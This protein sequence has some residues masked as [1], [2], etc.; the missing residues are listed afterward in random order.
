MKNSGSPDINQIDDA[1]LTVAVY[2]CSADGDLTRP[3]DWIS[4]IAS[5]NESTDYNNRVA[6]AANRYATLQ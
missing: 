4:A 1:A 2:L 3:E 6:E 5:Y